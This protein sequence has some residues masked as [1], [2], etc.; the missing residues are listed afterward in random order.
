M[1]REFGI[2]KLTDIDSTYRPLKWYEICNS[3]SQLKL[4][5]SM[6]KA[7]KYMDTIS[8]NLVQVNGSSTKVWELSIMFIYSISIK[9]RYICSTFAYKTLLCQ[10][11]CSLKSE[12]SFNYFYI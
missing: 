5:Y 3:S 6:V 11:T 9:Y 8:Y 1:E 7:V 12:I 2:E 10:Y 4:K